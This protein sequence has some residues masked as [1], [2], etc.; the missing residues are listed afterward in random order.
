MSLRR[1]AVRWQP[2]YTVLAHRTSITSAETPARHHVRPDARDPSGN[3]HTWESVVGTF[4]DEF[5]LYTQHR[6]SEVHLTDAAQAAM[7]RCLDEQ[8]ASEALE[9]YE[10][11]CRCGLVG[12]SHTLRYGTCRTS[13]TT[14]VSRT[15]T[16][17]A[18]IS[19]DHLAQRALAHLPHRH[20][21]HSMLALLMAAELDVSS[22]TTDHGD[23]GR[24]E[25]SPHGSRD[26]NLTSHNGYA[27]STTEDARGRYVEIALLS[28]A[29]TPS[30]AEKARIRVQQRL[31]TL[32]TTRQLRQPLGKECCLVEMLQLCA[33]SDAGSRAFTA[34]RQLTDEI[35]VGPLRTLS[36]VVLH[37]PF[38][39]L[40]PSASW[41][42]QEMHW[43][44]ISSSV[45]AQSLTPADVAR[46]TK[47]EDAVSPYRQFCRN[48]L[49]FL[50]RM[51]PN[52][53]MVLVRR[54][55]ETLVLP[56]SAHSIFPESYRRLRPNAAQRRCSSAS[57]AL[58][59][60]GATFDQMAAPECCTSW[61]DSATHQ[62]FG[63][64]SFDG[65]VSPLLR[66]EY[67]VKR[68]VHHNVIVPD[69]AYVLQR[70]QQLKQLARHREVIVTHDV[71]LDLVAAASLF[72]HPARFHARR[73][74][75][76][77]MCA[78][79]TAVT[80]KASAEARGQLDMEGLKSASRRR[81]QQQ[82]QSGFTLLGLQDE[83]ALLERCPER[84]YLSDFPSTASLSDWALMGQWTSFSSAACLGDIK[85][86]GCPS[87][88]LV[89]KELE[90]MI[91]AHDRGEDFL[92]NNAKTATTSTCVGI[93]SLVEHILQGNRNVASQKMSLSQQSAGQLFKNRS[94]GLWARMPVVIA[95]T[96]DSTRA[97]AFTVGLDMYP[98]AGVAP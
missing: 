6:S 37:H 76:D 51:V 77:I 81:N 27:T 43:E 82:Q 11:L 58:S 25:A 33:P 71:F 10:A 40:Q 68:R 66:V 85:Y 62:L 56:A 84:F 87:V 22:S 8:R 15:R 60:R 97:A 24:A 23:N 39:H 30:A 53:D 98:P 74:L 21:Q 42:Q 32:H 69:T 50:E 80:G 73:V 70:F 49:M 29:E 55:A 72:T 78:T 14:T 46:L 94:R 3:S 92:A 34:A 95:T 61:T 91:A 5:L 93:D 64:S 52:W 57:V 59:A 12:M 65:H 47:I 13:P 75:R 1:S 86:G 48:S 96:N 2:A 44:E 79:T 9:V 35:E 41:A 89:A 7:L 20:F 36:H 63:D 54:V 31:H 83:L 45:R 18:F 38:T 88:V 28:Q 67:L 16:S 4:Y 17:Q 26:P 19:L 90:R